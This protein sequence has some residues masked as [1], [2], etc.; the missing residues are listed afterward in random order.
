MPVMESVTQVGAH[1]V[2]GLFALGVIGC[3]VTIP[4]CA[5]KF[6]AILFEEDAEQSQSAGFQVM[7]VYQS[8][9]PA[10][11]SQ[12]TPDTIGDQPPHRRS[13]DTAKN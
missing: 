2:M 5:A 1:L 8:T 7:P 4:I 11:P 3:A 10:A 13:G 12:T 9:E 6:F